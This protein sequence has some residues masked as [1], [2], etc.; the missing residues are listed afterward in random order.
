MQDRPKSWLRQIVRRTAAPAGEPADPLLAALAALVNGAGGLF[1]AETALAGLPLVPGERLPARLFPRA[2]Q[3]FG[4]K[5]EVVAK[6]PSQV[7]ALVAPFIALLADGNAA[8]VLAIDA[9]KGK[10]Q[11]VVPALSQQRRS[12]GLD[13]L[14]AQASGDVILV[15]KDE[16]LDA[17]GETAGAGHWLWGG[18]ARLWP[19]WLQ[20]GVAALLINVLS[21]AVPIFV[22]SVYDR[23][24]PNQSQPTLWALTAGVLIALLFDLLLKQLRASVLDQAGGQI[25]MAAFARLFRQA[26][27]LPMAERQQSPGALASQIRE[28][29]TV[30]EFFASSSVVAVTDLVFVGLIVAVMFALVGPV[31]FVVVA[32]LPVILILTLLLQWP[33]GRAVKTSQMQASRRQVVLI[34]TLGA[35]ETVKAA[36]AEGIMQRRFEDAVAATLRAS[37]WTRFW[38]QLNINLIG[39]IQ[40]GVS[41]AVVVWGVFLAIDGQI[42]VG[43]IIAASMLSGRVLQPLGSI[44]MLLTRAQAAFSAMGGLNALMRRPAENAGVHSGAGLEDASLELKGVSFTYPGAP[45]P[46]LAGVGF[47]IAAGERVGVIGRVGSGKT[48][49]GKLACGLWSPGE[50]TIL[51][52]GRE[53]RSVEAS[54]LRAHVGLVTQEI[55]L[56]SGTLYD[57]IVIGARTLAEAAVLDAC[58]ISGVSE[59]ARRNPM[60]LKMPA[61]ERGRSLSGGQRQ[62]VALARALVREP[63]I[64]I[65]D[66]PSSALDNASE[67]DLVRRLREWADARSATLIVSSQRMAMLELCDR[68]I[69]LDQGRVVADG[70]KGDVLRLLS[71]RPAGAAQAQG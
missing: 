50:G 9:G 51:V 21:L 48:T 38:S 34:E 16:T 24:I 57:N 27:A 56:F 7:P 8:V 28:F 31:T 40:Q 29:E 64:L 22:M 65:L 61:G 3:K 30:R 10:A 11:I 45:A 19:S 66:E 36:G 15:A 17:T 26:L 46:A 4:L 59:F 20:V 39:L 42:T 47:R 13:A 71:G 44:A 60:G 5:A 62:A 53:I 2:A 67:A 37:L 35:I 14:D 54:E 1:S 49:L 58:D 12:V 52:G 25:D 33:L 43:G 32:A 55:E 69:V 6:R 23:V 18:M 63:R 68:L 41:V 70:A